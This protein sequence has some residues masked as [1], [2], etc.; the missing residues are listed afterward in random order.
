M[1]ATTPYHP[2]I[3]RHLQVQNCLRAKIRTGEWISGE[4][5]PSEHDLMRR[6]RVSRTTVREALAALKRDGLIVRLRPRGTFVQANALGADETPA[7]TNLIGGYEATVG[8][9]SS[10]VVPAPAHIASHFGMRR[11]DPLHKFV[12]VEM[13]NGSPLSVIVNFLRPAL[14]KRIRPRDLMRSSLLRIVQ[15][16]LKIPLGRI[17]MSLEARIA[18]EEVAPNLGIDL[19]QPVLFMRLLVHNRHARLIE[20]SETFYRGDRYRYEAELSSDDLENP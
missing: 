20:I 7:I 10:E 4:R 5:L 19:M 9:L 12:R 8:V 16:N 18:D 14:G 2:I 13:V 17:R 11:G 6:F 1:P 15:R 3:P